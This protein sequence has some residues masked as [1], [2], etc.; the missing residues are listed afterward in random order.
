MIARVGFDDSD[1]RGSIEFQHLNS[2]DMTRKADMISPSKAR[3][4]PL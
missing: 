4:P 3:F 2:I 1:G